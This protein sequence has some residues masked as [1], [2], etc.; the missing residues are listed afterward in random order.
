MCEFA[1]NNVFLLFLFFRCRYKSSDVLIRSQLQEDMY[2]TLFWTLKKPVFQ[3]WSIYIIGSKC[4][5]IFLERISHCPGKNLVITHTHTHTHTHTYL[6][7]RN[8]NKLISCH[9][10]LDQY[11]IVCHLW[12]GQS[13]IASTSKLL[14]NI[15]GC[16]SCA[17]VLAF[18]AHVPFFQSILQQ[19]VLQPL[20]SQI[21]E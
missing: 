2:P 17:C 7:V 21:W 1:W 19:K 4:Y 9:L 11:H 13:F 5:S 14:I 16:G 3:V 18:A 20:N 12:P 6:Q 15:I 10:C 8:Q